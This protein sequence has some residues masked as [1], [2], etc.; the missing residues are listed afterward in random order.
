MKNKTSWF[1]FL[2]KILVYFEFP[3]SQIAHK[4]EIIIPGKECQ[5]RQ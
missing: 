3:I 2:I 4:Y 5:A 1:I